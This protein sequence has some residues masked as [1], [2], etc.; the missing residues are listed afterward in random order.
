MLS[1]ITVSPIYLLKVNTGNT[2][3]MWEIWSQIKIKTPKRRH[4]CFSVVF[5]INFEHISHTLLVFL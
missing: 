1:E 3:K 5:T 2:R 4:W